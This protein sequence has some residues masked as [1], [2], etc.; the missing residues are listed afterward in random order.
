VAK[1]IRNKEIQLDA[2][3][4][5]ERIWRRRTAM[6]H[7]AGNRCFIGTAVERLILRSYNLAK[8]TLA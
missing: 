5:P 6:E 1:N 3:M 8:P 2:V 4:G 7:Y